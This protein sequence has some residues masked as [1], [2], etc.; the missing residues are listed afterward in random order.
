VLS[1]RLRSI[2]DALPLAPG[3]RVIE[4]GCGPGAAVR[5]VAEIVG[6]TGTVLAVDRSTR[7]VAQLRSSAGDLIAAGRIHAVVAAAESFVLDP[8]DDLYDLAF[9]VRVGVFD[10]RHPARHDEAVARVFAALTPTGRF[11]IDGGDPLREV[12]RPHR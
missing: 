2:V 11:F 12:R 5:A 7:A 4:I 1:A 3:M 8:S 6:P 9:A 10:G